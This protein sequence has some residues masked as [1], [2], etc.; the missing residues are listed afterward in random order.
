MPT[1]HASCMRCSHG[2]SSIDDGGLVFILGCERR[3]TE[4]VKDRQI[5]TLVGPL[6][7]MDVF[8]FTREN[9]GLGSE[10]C[11]LI[12]TFIHCGKA[13]ILRLIENQQS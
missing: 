3:G 2:F 4:S 8:C 12:Y 13:P 7:T 10:A 5:A 9:T 11:I 1:G 6:P